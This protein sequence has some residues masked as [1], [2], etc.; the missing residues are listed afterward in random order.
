MKIFD[1]SIDMI[2]VGPSKVNT[3]MSIND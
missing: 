1:I 3:T 2:F